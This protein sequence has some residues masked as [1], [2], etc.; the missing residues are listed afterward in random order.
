MIVGGEPVGTVALGELPAAAAAA[1]TFTPIVSPGSGPGM[2]LAG[3]GG[4]AG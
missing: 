1:T 3:N 2:K 4:L